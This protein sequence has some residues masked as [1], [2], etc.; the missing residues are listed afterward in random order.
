MKEKSFITLTTDGSAHL[1][2]KLKQCFTRKE[3][4]LPGLSS[5]VYY[6]R[7]RP[8]ACPRVEHL[9]GASLKKHWTRL[10][11]FARDKYPSFLRTSINY[12]CKKIYNIGGRF[13]EQK[14]ILSSSFRRDQIYKCQRNDFGVV[15]LKSDLGVKQTHF[16]YVYGAHLIDLLFTSRF[17]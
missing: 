13:V 9:K 1:R 15:L 17:H 10:E 2:Y 8:G 3:V 5:L 16:R 7:V 12:G 4:F 11:I 6:L 14:L